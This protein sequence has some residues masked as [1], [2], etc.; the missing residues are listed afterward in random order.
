MGLCS[1]F[2]KT[3]GC[4]FVGVLAILA[5]FAFDCYSGRS[6]AVPECPFND[7]FDREATDLHNIPIPFTT[8]G[9]VSHGH[10]GLDFLGMQ[11]EWCVLSK[12]VYLIS[13]KTTHKTNPKMQNVSFWDA[14]KHKPGTFHETGFTLLK[15]E[16]M[17]E[18]TD[19]DTSGLHDPVNADVVK[20]HKQMDPHIR[21]LY[22]KVK[23]I[24]WM[25]N[26]VRGGYVGSHPKAFYAHI[27]YHPN[28]TGRIGKVFLICHL[29][30]LDVVLYFFYRVP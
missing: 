11:S 7:H 22:P 9:Q 29:N 13:A 15:L 5:Y 24:H 23:R 1:F 14:R 10:L 27:D 16:K 3:T 18:T 8:K 19:W 26:V 2:F 4:V 12:I 30:Q 17:P 28:N 6:H 20:F 25:Q 21:K